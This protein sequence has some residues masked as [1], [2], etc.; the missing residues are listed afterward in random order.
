MHG[1]VHGLNKLNIRW[2]YNNKMTNYSKVFTFQ[3]FK[4][5]TNGLFIHFNKLK[6]MY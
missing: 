3:K 2:Y 1:N 5:D 4:T 6:K